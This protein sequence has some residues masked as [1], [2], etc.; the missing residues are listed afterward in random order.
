MQ[1][2]PKEKERKKKKYI[3]ISDSAQVTGTSKLGL[4]LLQTKPLHK[5]SKIGGASS[6]ELQR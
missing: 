5:T 3:S 6:L 1:C 4:V 2:K